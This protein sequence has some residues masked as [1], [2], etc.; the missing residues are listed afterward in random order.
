VTLSGFVI[1]FSCFPAAVPI[2]L[3]SANWAPAVWVGFMLLAVAIYMVHGN[4]HYTPVVLV[5][6]KRAGGGSSCKVLTDMFGSQ[7]WERCYSIFLSGRILLP[8]DRYGIISSN[9]L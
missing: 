5:E 3:T 8:N 1:G 9:V 6:G 2:T 4:R 7:I